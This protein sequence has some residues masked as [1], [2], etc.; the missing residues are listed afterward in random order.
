MRISSF[1]HVQLF[2]NNWWQSWFPRCFLLSSNIC[3][4]KLR[5]CLGVSMDEPDSLFHS[6][7]AAGFTEVS[8]SFL[9]FTKTSFY[10]KCLL[11]AFFVIFQSIFLIEL[12]KQKQKIPS[13]FIIFIAYNKFRACHFRSPQ[14]NKNETETIE[15]EKILHDERRRQEDKKCYKRKQR[16]SFTR[17]INIHI[18]KCRYTGKRF[19]SSILPSIYS[20]LRN[21]L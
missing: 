12:W 11:I 4:N 8:V 20:Y 7:L 3:F 17:S 14:R 21:E 5:S 6:G 16:Y 1:T 9:S 2:I 10:L 18:E 15:Q 13:I 19:T